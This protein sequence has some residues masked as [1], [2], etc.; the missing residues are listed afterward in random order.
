MVRGNPHDVEPVAVLDLDHLTGCGDDSVNDSV[1]KHLV[2]EIHTRLIHMGGTGA[3][4]RAAIRYM[5]GASAME[6]GVA[7]AQFDLAMRDA[8]QQFAAVVWRELPTLDRNEPTSEV[9]PP[10]CASGAVSSRGT[11]E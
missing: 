8:Q 3:R 5:G 10:E 11:Q 9:S 7:E 6:H 1:Q 4:Y 2:R